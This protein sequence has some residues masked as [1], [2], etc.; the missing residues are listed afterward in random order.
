LEQVTKKLNKLFR[1]WSGYEAGI[2]TPLPRSGSDRLYW[3]LSRG[4][5][6]AI[7]A[8]NPNIEEND[9]FFSFTLHFHK[10]GLK[11]PALYGIDKDRQAYLQEDLGDIPL[12]S[13]M[14]KRQPGEPVPGEIIALYQKSLSALVGFQVTAGKGIDYTRCYPNAS[15]DKR[16]ILWDLNYFKYYFLK[17]HLPFH[18]RRLEDDFNTLADFL[19]EAGSDHF[20]YRD[21]QSRNIFIK[22]GQPHFIDYQG[23]RRGPLQYDVASLL[24]Q[25]KAGLPE[26][27]R[28]YLLDHYLAELSSQISVDKEDFKEYYYGFVLIRML[29]VLGAYGFRGL[30][31]KKHHFLV[32]IPYALKS[33]DWWMDNITLPCNLPELSAC[34]DELSQI[35]KYDHYLLPGTGKLVLTLK[36]FSY[37]DGIPDD[38]SGNGG[39]FVFD[40]RALPN[41]GREERYRAFNGKDPVIIDYLKNEPP[42]LRFL[43]E[44]EKL[45]C[46]SVDNYLERG[47][48]SLSVAFGCTGGQHR[49]VYC[50][51]TMAK[52]LKKKYPGI[53]LN[54]IHTKI[55]K[56]YE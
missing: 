55:A 29:Q 52:Q 45:I 33:L 4:T 25:V 19:C 22:D 26:E 11:V 7:G 44:A 21:F 54:V 16:A 2:I 48:D 30:I 14:D 3:R 6:S 23:G 36:S 27:L 10:K 5:T 38:Y 31:E 41:P 39:G 51:E 8:W 49:S 37:K 1:Q 43:E 9:A 17:L 34:L 12:F 18:E 20:M 50:T 47:F 40:C 56:E 35:D 32:S 13:L 42:V 28:E 15:F 24:F 46:Q 53:E